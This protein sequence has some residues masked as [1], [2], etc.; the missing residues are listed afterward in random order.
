MPASSCIEFEN[1]SF[2]R[3]KQ[4]PHLRIDLR[5]PI[6]GCNFLIASSPLPNVN[7]AIFMFSSAS[8]SL[9]LQRWKREATDVEEKGGVSVRVDGQFMEKSFCEK[10]GERRGCI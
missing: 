6:L 4:I 8:S 5:S 3:S 1:T 9:V 10:G 2:G 7:S